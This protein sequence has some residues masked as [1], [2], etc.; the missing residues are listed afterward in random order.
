VIRDRLKRRREHRVLDHDD[1]DSNAA[2]A[3]DAGLPSV[4]S[5][6]RWAT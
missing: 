2:T 4:I 6:L 5:R 3:A 1:A